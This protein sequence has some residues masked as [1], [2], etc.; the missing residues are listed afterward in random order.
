LQYRLA[1]IRIFALEARMLYIGNEKFPALAVESV[2]I[3]VDL[4]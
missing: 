2:K 1:A 4:V 3:P